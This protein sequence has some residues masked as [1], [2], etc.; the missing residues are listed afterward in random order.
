MGENKEIYLSRALAREI[1][2]ML[3]EGKE[4]PLN[5]YVAYMELFKYYQTQIENGEM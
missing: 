1:H 5:V 2:L 4:L 3:E